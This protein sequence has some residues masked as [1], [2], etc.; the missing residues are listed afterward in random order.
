[1]IETQKKKKKRIMKKI[2]LK[3]HVEFEVIEDNLMEDTTSPYQPEGSTTVTDFEVASGE[4]GGETD[5]DD[6]LGG[7]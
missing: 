2:Y 6:L 5:D 3:P 1:M 7:F 4:T